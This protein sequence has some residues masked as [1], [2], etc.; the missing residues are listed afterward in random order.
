MK[1]E[2]IGKGSPEQ[3]RGLPL[4]VKPPGRPY[5]GG[6]D[7]PPFLCDAHVHVSA[8]KPL[9][10]SEQMLRGLMERF[11]YE[12]MAVLSVPHSSR[13]RNAFPANN[14]NVLACKAHLNAENP[15]RKVYACAG[16]VHSPDD[17]PEDLLAQAQR[18][19]AEGFDGFKMLEGKPGL[20][21]RVGAPL[22]GP[23]YEPFF[24]W[25]E[26]ES[27]PITLHSGDPADF[28][29]SASSSGNGPKHDWSYDDSF[30]SLEQIRAETEG[31]LRRHPRLRLTLAHMFFLGDDPA[32]AARWL[33]SYPGLCF[34]LTPGSEMYAGFTRR[35]DEWRAF[36]LRY[37]DRLLFGSDSDNWH[38]SED[39]ST[40]D[41]NFGFPIRLVLDMLADGPPFR[42]HDADLGELVPLALPVDVR[43]AI[44]HDNFI[45]RFGAE[46][47][48]A[49][50]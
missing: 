36:F 32:E 6:M 30:P 46:P 29:G 38:S 44:V 31:I 47:R 1:A 10:Y 13:Q 3:K 4:L 15:R 41:W 12:R 17:T 19:V 22:D 35:W 39:L 25:A 45:A 21:K 42:F 7:T 8:D 33:D 28:W 26:K 2:G 49:L 16:F 24:A 27:W 34:D 50:R 37:A 20:R 48:P 9:A 40:Y 11:G 14:R 23:L 43:R 5:N 18:A